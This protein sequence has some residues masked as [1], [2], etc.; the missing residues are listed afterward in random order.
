[1]FVKG[2]TT[3]G[4]ILALEVKKQISPLRFAPV[5]MTS[6]IYGPLRMK[7]RKAGATARAKITARAA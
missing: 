6:F 1:V 4:V 2:A 3:N 5:E 7:D